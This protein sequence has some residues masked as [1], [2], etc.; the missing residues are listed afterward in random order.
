MPGILYN[1]IP[2]LILGTTVPLPG[3]M[4]RSSKRPCNSPRATQ[5]LHGGGRTLYP[6]LSD[7]KG[8]APRHTATPGHQTDRPRGLGRL[9]PHGK[10]SIGKPC[11]RP[12][13]TPQNSLKSKRVSLLL[14]EE[15]KK[16]RVTFTCQAEHLRLYSSNGRIPAFQ[17]MS[18]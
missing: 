2:D 1:C 6:G 11:F 7:F 4:E 10:S 18:V 13:L 12:I 15:S 3:W 9:G 14:K 16:G 17:M 8:L 5:L